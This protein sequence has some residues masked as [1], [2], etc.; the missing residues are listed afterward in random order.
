M[1]GVLRGVSGGLL[2][3]TDGVFLE[4]SSLGFLRVL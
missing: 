4:V 1:P 2:G 3:A